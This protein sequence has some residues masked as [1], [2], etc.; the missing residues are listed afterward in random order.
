MS[1]ALAGENLFLTGGA[2]TG[3]SLTLNQ[4]IAALREKHGGE[5]V[6]VTA[7][8]GIAA[9]V[10]GGTT[11]HSYAGVG[12]GTGTVDEMATKLSRYAPDRWRRTACLVIDEVS[13][14]DGELFD[15]LIQAYLTA[16]ENTRQSIYLRMLS[17]SELIAKDKSQQ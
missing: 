1:R 4:I 12:K 13:M 16:E 2:G 10:I 15:T 9:T 14:L 17:M 6:H 5:A 8:T 11:L 3:K 7:S